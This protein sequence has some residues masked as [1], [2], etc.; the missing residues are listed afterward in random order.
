MK[1]VKMRKWYANIKRLGTVE[2]DHRHNVEKN[3]D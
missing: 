2:L 1:N 3:K